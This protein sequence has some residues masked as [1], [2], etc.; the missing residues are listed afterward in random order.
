M[1]GNKCSTLRASWAGLTTLIEYEI[2]VGIES[3]ATTD[4]SQYT[5]DC[6]LGS[7]C[8]IQTVFHLNCLTAQLS[9]EGR[10]AVEGAK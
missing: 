10:A 4:I 2:T 3:V 5:V 8:Y 7:L 1:L 6:F 9:Y